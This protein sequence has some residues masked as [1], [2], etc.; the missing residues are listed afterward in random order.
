MNPPPFI[1]IFQAKFPGWIPPED[2]VMD[3]GPMYQIP[4]GPMCTI[5]FSPCGAAGIDHEGS[6]WVL[7]EDFGSP[8]KH[9]LERLTWVRF[10]VVAS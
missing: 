7:A 8:G 3:G 5:R 1:G 4:G 2:V 10:P 9:A 6:V